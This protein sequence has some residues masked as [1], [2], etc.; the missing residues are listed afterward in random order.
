[1]PACG[2]HGEAC[3]S[4]GPQIWRVCRTTRFAAPR[5]GKSTPSGFIIR[6][7]PGVGQPVSALSLDRRMSD[8]FGIGSRDLRSKGI[9]HTSESALAP[10][11][12]MQRREGAGL[13]L[14]L[15]RGQ[16]CVNGW[17][18]G[19]DLDEAREFQDLTDRRLRIHK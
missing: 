14:V 2:A 8:D 1:N 13:G 5:T 3:H 6:S 19:K 4:C 9:T 7:M 11:H 12:L 15:N 16:C 18:D 10:A 17:I